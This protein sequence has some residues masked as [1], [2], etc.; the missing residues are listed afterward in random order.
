MHHR[1]WSLR[2]STYGIWYEVLLSQGVGLMDV[3]GMFWGVLFWSWFV[4]YVGG[5]SI[6]SALGFGIVVFIFC[7]VWSLFWR[8]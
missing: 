5:A 7:A 3:F 1:C 8:C 6:I 4:W 2:A